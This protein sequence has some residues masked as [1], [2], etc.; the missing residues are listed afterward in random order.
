MIN[1]L[2]ELYDAYN[3]NKDDIDKYKMYEKEIL[4]IFNNHNITQYKENNN[5]LVWIG[6]YY[7]EI[8][9][10]YDKM[11]EYYLMA[12]EKGILDAMNSLGLYYENIEKN[13]DKMKKYY[14]M[15]IQKGH[16][17]AKKDI[18]KITTPLERYILYKEKDIPFEEEITN[19]IHIYNNKLN[20]FSKIDECGICIENNKECILL[21][22]FGH[23]VCKDCYIKLYDKPCPFCRL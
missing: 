17:N 16:S 22:C 11:K 7:Y 2:E 12:I 19:G 3:Y 4:D 18:I 21:N 6:N 1:T 8:E 14:L 20:K 10:N 13:Y 9:K 15:A 23:Y 5:L